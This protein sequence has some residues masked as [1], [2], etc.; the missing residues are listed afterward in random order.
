MLFSIVSVHIFMGHPLNALTEP[1]PVFAYPFFVA[2][3]LGWA[4]TILRT[5]PLS[6]KVTPSTGKI[7]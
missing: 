4:W 3:L 2:T 7:D 5:N 1:L 6:M